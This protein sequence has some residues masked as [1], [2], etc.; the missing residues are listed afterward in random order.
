MIGAKRQQHAALPH[1]QE[2]E[3]LPVAGSRGRSA[4]GGGER[5][6]ERSAG[7]PR[8]RAAD[9]RVVGEEAAQARARR[10]RGDRRGRG[11]GHQAGRSSADLLGTPQS[12][13]WCHRA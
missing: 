11:H 5:S 10:G 13:G 2:V 3:G 8:R 7:G 4:A 12:H 9:S 6:V 1:G